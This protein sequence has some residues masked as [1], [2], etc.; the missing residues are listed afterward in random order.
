[1]HNA[2]TLTQPIPEVAH[3]RKEQ[4]DACRVRPDMGGFFRYFGHPDGI[5]LGVKAVKRSGFRIQLVAE[6]EHQLA[7][8]AKNIGCW[9]KAQVFL[10]TI[11]H[12][13]E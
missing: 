3:G 6:D 12:S 8:A 7:R 5:E 9:T 13:F 10:R 2:T 11:L 4:R 1:M